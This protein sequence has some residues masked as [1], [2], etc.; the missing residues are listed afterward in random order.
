MV[1]WR[2]TVWSVEKIAAFGSSYAERIPIP[3][4][5]VCAIP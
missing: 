4:M 5:V 3:M 2:D 1:S